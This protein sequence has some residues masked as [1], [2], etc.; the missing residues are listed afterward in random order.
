M[1][2]AKTPTTPT[3]PANAPTIPTNTARM[4]T[5]VPDPWYGRLD[6]FYDTLT[7]VEAGATGIVKYLR[8]R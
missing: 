2:P 7:V 6:G 1:N 8:R 5:T 3:N 4:E